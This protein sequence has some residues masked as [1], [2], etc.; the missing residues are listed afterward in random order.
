MELYIHIP[1]CMRKCRYCDFLSGSYDIDIRKKYTEALI[2]ELLFYAAK[3]SDEKVDS[4]FIGGG[5]P[6]FLETELMK[7]ILVV[8]SSKY[9]LSDNVEYTIECNP[10]TAS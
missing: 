5:T 1:F 9:N 10:G 2:N 6:T 4:V 8:V 7:Q 3:C